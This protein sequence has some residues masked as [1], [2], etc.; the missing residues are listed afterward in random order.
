MEFL[1]PLA[2]LALVVVL[3]LLSLLGNLVEEF[4]S[5][6]LRQQV[7]ARKKPSSTLYFLLE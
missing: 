3:P 1:S 2:P 5:R 4:P 7:L 6:M